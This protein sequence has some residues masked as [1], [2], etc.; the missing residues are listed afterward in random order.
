MRPGAGPDGP[1]FTIIDAMR[2]RPLRYMA[3]RRRLWRNMAHPVQNGKKGFVVSIWGLKANEL[4][5]NDATRAW[6][7]NLVA[8]SAPANAVTASTAINTGQH[9]Q[10]YPHFSPQY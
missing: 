7:T 3:L 2:A 4:G 10:R 5:V 9:G 6:L 1:D 8:A